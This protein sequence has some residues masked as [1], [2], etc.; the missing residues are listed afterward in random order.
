MKRPA[1]DEHSMREILDRMYE[2]R[3]PEMKKVEND[4]NRTVVIVNVIQT[5]QDPGRVGFWS[6]YND[7]TG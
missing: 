1:L 2:R 4:D 3:H 6:L 7:Y 5:R